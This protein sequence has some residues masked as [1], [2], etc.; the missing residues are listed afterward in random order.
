MPGYIQVVC[1]VAVYCGVPGYHFWLCQSYAG[2]CIP[3]YIQ[4]THPAKHAPSKVFVRH[5]RKVCGWGRVTE[6]WSEGTRQASLFCA[7]VLPMWDL[8]YLSFISGQLAAFSPPLPDGCCVCERFTIVRKDT[9]R[10]D[11]RRCGGCT[12]CA[13]RRG[14][15]CWWCLV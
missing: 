8:V 10:R 1:S 14:Q 12:E 13:N 2:R 3:G 11:A 5:W 4:S 6:S 15:Q 7:L 9:R